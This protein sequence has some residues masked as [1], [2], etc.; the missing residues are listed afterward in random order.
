ML[1]LYCLQDLQHA[2]IPKFSRIKFPTRTTAAIPSQVLLMALATAWFSRSDEKIGQAEF[3]CRNL[4]SEDLKY[5]S[6]T[7]QT[8]Q[9]ID[10][11]LRPKLTMTGV[12]K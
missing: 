12:N 7:K 2:V 8:K 10:L 4:L 1:F 9:I 5:L 6:C 3:S 11:L